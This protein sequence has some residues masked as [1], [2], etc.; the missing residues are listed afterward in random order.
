MSNKA[1]STIAD[2][3]VT[4][5]TVGAYSYMTKV[6]KFTMLVGIPFVLDFNSLVLNSA[7]K[8]QQP[9]A[10]NYPLANIFRKKKTP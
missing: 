9:K 2:I 5:C 6:N 1:E 4:N 8:T 3:S 10:L 7:W